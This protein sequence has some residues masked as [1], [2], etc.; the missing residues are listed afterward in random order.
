M[1]TSS[2]LRAQD[3]A[4]ALERD[5]LTGVLKPRERL[6]EVQLTER[7][8]VSRTPVREALL[9]LKATGLIELQPRRGATV[10]SFD[11]KALLE[12]FETMAFYESLC[13]KLAARRAYAEDLDAIRS[14]HE[15]SIAAAN[16]GDI[17]LYFLRNIAFHESLY[18][19]SRNSYMAGLASDLNKLLSPYRR[20]QLHCANRITDSHDE[21]LRILQAIEERD[22]DLAAQL[23][24]DHITVQGGNFTDFVARLDS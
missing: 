8:G 16:D 3:L 15:D 19:A 9:Q 6:N 4:K 7:F 14:A 22:S 5:I 23:A 21:H 24:Y 2:P 18:R 1:K 20:L 12:M 17:E 10:A 13:A 11:L